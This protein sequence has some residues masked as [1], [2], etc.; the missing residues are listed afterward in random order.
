M[1]EILELFIVQKTPTPCSLILSYLFPGLLA[2]R[3]GSRRAFQSTKDFPPKNSVLSH[4]QGRAKE[5]PMVYG[6][7]RS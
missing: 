2:P 7:R 6:E 5:S 1:G 3:S 4:L